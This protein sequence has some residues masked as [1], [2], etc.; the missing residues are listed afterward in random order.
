VASLHVPPTGDSSAR[1]A[2]AG[3]G[4][5][6]LVVTG[7]M[8]RAGIGD[9]CERARGMLEGSEAHLVVL[10][11]GEIRG[12]D[13]VT[14]DTL[15]RLQLTVG[16]VGKRIRF[17]RACGEV[18]EL[19]DLMGLTDVLRLDP[20]SPVEPGRETEQREQVRGVEEE[21]DP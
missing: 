21:R 16:R 13:A 18:D 3:E 2:S 7:P 9:L 12:A 10:D 5:V 17:R 15:A 1:G 20:S 14:V 19:V 8:S 11:L 6:A 4:E